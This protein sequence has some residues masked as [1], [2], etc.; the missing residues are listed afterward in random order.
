[1]MPKGMGSRI[2]QNVGT[3]FE[4]NND[5]LASCLVNQQQMLFCKKEARSATKRPSLIIL[6]K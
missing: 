1:M 4:T 6:Y 3:G 5:K 2:N